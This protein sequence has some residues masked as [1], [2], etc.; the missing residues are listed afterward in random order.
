MLNIRTLWTFATAEMRSCRRL[1]R[2]W[3]FIVIA[4]LFCIGWYIGMTAQSMSPTPPEGWINVFMSPRYTVSTM[5]NAFV[6]IFSFGI[7]FLTFD[8]HARD[9]QNRIR[10]VVDSLPATNLE[11]IVG[12][13][14]GI[15]LLLLIPCL[16]FLTIVACYEF[17]THVTGFQ[18]RMGIQPMSVMSLFLWGLIP[19][20]V[21]Y[22]ALVVFLATL[23]RFR[24][25]VAGI[26]VAVLIGS[27]WL[28]HQIPLRFQESLAQFLG[29][30]SFPSDLAP[31]FVTPAILG[32]KIAFLCVAITLLLFAANLQPRTEPQR[33][34]NSLLGVA[35]AGIAV[36]TFFLLI[37]A[38]YRADNLKEE[39]GR[40]HQQQSVA[41]F[42]D[43]Q[44]LDGD[45]EI[46]PGQ[47]ITLNLTLSVVPPTA[48]DTNSVIFSLNPGY[49][50]QELFID[51]EAITDF[52]FKS[53]LITIPSHLL[54]DDE[55]IVRV[56]AQGKID[57]RFAYLDQARDFLRITHQ[58]VPRIGLRSSIFHGEFVALMPGS[59]WYPMSGSATG[60]DLLEQHPRDLFTTNLSISVPRK[61]QVVTVGNRKTIDDQKRNTFQFQ[62]NAPVPELA[63]IASTFE[64]RETT[65]EGVNFEVLFSKKHSRS[66][67]VLSPIHEKVVEW[68][69]E[70]IKAAQALSLEYPYGTFYAVEVPS[71][72][73]IYGG[74]WRMESVLQ[75]PGMMLIR[76]TTLPTAQFERRLRPP[77]GRDLESEE[78]SYK[79]IFDDILR[80]VGNDQQ[81][82]SPFVGFSRNF[83]SHQITAT[84]HG[85]TTLQFLLDQLTNT[86][87]TGLESESIIST[88]DFGEKIMELIVGHT[89]DTRRSY[90]ATKNRVVIS[91]LPSTWEVLNK[92]ALFDLD[93]EFDPIPS[94]RALLTKGFALAKSIRT[95]YG[96]ES[97]G[98]LL[99]QLLSQYQGQSFTLEDL[100]SIAAEFDLDFDEWVLPWL[101]Q[102]NSPGFL[103][104][105]PTVSKLEHPELGRAEYQTTL[106]FHNAEA[107]PGFARVV[108]TTDEED[109]RLY[110]WG[111]GKFNYSDPIFVA[112]NETKRIAI[113][114]ADPLTGIWIE[115]FLSHNRWPIYVKVPEFNEETARISPALPF[116]ADVEWESPNNGTVIVDDLDPGFAIVST[117]TESNEDEYSVLSET[118]LGQETDNGL[119]FYGSILGRWSRGYDARSFG[120]Y[121]NTHAVIGRGEGSTA[122][123]FRANLPNPGEWKLEIFLPSQLFSTLISATGVLIHIQG[124]G[125]QRPSN[126]LEGV[127][128]YALE[129][130]DGN[131]AQTVTIDIANAQQGWNEVSTF[132]LNSTNVD[133]L[134]GDS[135]RLDQRAVFADAIRWTPVPSDNINTKPA[136]D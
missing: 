19:N 41:A 100:L 59:F 13:F 66:L 78:D 94:Y 63:L 115:T 68:V 102:T 43:I 113:K 23:V 15:L 133:V 9:V 21:F 87:I 72:L 17:L 134:L 88:T 2:T 108:W 129:I 86:L 109:Q 81:G 119:P 29:S 3:V 58:S 36:T 57:G 98:A 46:R 107:M 28:E 104:S 99:K 101:E 124:M 5:M 121:R 4:V 52:S 128:L 35:T 39:W 84:Q 33:P 16:F 93:F 83:L 127:E 61:W 67:D 71:N 118:Y 74:G 34:L 62:S 130:K 47:K 32:N 12:R 1:A 56:R 69:A 30:T 89:P 42:P 79:R 75:P 26:A 82:G 77:Q 22:G 10:D 51:H 92:S 117:N 37:S 135:S 38:V 49:K 64:N 122:A 105:P 31:V 80:Y 114:S 50:I 55:H 125:D 45:V 60:R 24:A 76:E 20:L 116:V 97:L 103:V 120:R 95:F 90:W 73:R 48:N 91:T 110:T 136:D 14:I 53:G 126:Q 85:A 7:V 54:P 123:R 8:I 40:L 132:D 131:T 6:A 27:L 112:A 106:V 25:L 18:F 70:R 111:W 44:H 11:V 96:D 65:I